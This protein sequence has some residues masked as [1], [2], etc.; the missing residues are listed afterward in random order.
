MSVSKG[1]SDGAAKQGFAARLLHGRSQMHIQQCF[2]CNVHSMI[3]C[4]LRLLHACM[5][6]YAHR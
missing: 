4:I 3:Q 1:V 5:H 2:V 6:A